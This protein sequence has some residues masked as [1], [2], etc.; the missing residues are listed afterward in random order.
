MVD[1]IFKLGHRPESRAA[2]GCRDRGE[3]PSEVRERASFQAAFKKSAI[4]SSLA[5]AHH[6]LHLGELV[7]ERVLAHYWT[8]KR[9]A[10]RLSCGKELGNLPIMTAPEASPS[11]DPAGRVFVTTHW[12]VVWKAR[13]KDSPDSAAARERLCRT[14]WAPLYH[15]MRRAGH[16]PH[17]AQDLTQEF[18]S[19]FLHREWL[20]HL[21]DQRGKFRSFL[22]TFL[23]HF[24]SDERAR[25]NAQK[26][27]GGQ[28]F[29]S[30]DAYEAEERE[31]IGP[32][33]GLTADQIYE[34]RWAET[35]LKKAMEQLHA[36][37]AANGK[38][39]LFD[40]LK[41]LQPG[42]HGEKSYAQIGAA[43][44]LTEQAVKNAALR[45]RRRYAQLLREEIAQTVLEP[46][47]V[48]EELRHLMQIF[49]R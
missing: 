33:N 8:V 31:F 38:A 12:S 19:R 4:A 48:N 24:L 35:V 9:D 21:Q 47:E 14:Y 43:L 7:H 11:T 26:R 15:Y 18:L 3:I 17:G 25:A 37:Y 40:Q 2:A 6:L 41:D 5:S 28:P 13:Q 32:V 27:G 30:L 45:F 39:A 10:G 46:D 22:L 44:G 1:G 42:E 49:S 29:V 16:S 20:D 36:E 34:R 23:K